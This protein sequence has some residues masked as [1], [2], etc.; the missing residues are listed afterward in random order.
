MKT[1][2]VH[3]LQHMHERDK[4][5]YRFVDRDPILDKVNSA[6]D[7]SKLTDKAIADKSGVS[8]STIRAWRYGDVKRPQHLTLKFVLDACGYELEVRKR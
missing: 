1:S 7:E 5:G 3:Y 4:F 6:M 2:N 8:V